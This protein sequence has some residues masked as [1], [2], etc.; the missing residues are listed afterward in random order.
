MTLEKR[1]IFILEHSINQMN[2]AASIA[3]IIEYEDRRRA[4]S[5]HLAVKMAACRLETTNQI[6]ILTPQT[7]AGTNSYRYYLR[8]DR[9]I[10]PS[11]GNVPAGQRP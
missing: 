8:D 6:G 2:D 5:M 7:Q 11:S 4:G 1:I 9:R 3:R 10:D